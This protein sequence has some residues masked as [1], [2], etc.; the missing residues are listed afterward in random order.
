[1]LFVWELLLLA[2][3]LSLFSWLRINSVVG[4]CCRFVSV[5]AVVCVGGLGVV[6]V[7]RGVV[8]A[9]VVRICC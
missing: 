9:V 7:V 2:V 6:G 4:L 1:M 3:L 8:V 5:V